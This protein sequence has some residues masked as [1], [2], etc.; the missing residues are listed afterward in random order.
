M[1]NTVKVKPI[2][3]VPRPIDH[4]LI[5]LNLL[6]VIPFENK[7][8]MDFSTFKQETSQ[9]KELM[10]MAM[11]F[12]QSVMKDESKLLI[13]SG[14]AGVGKTASAVCAAKELTARGKNVAWISEV[15]VESWA[16]QAS[17]IADLKYCSI[18][19]DKLL[20]TDPD[21]IFLDDDN[22]TGYSGNLLLEKIYSWYVSHQGKDYLLLPMSLFALKI[23]M[24]IS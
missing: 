16:G 7:T 1:E 23:V 19:I 15:M 14:K 20:A 9:Q 18:E 3:Y 4:A 11:Q 10:A 2:E 6:H 21:A 24:D 5:P 22:L 8:S 12:C 13:L 17:S